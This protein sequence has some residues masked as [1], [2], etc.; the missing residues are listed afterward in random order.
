MMSVFLFFFLA[1]LWYIQEQ[2]MNI[3]SM[4]YGKCTIV[5]FFMCNR[6][7]LLLVFL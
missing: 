7:T 5:C 2:N 1:H 3:K 4:S 6:S